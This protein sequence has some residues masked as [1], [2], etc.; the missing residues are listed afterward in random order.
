M[1]WIEFEKTLS[2]IIFYWKKGRTVCLKH[3]IPPLWLNIFNN[4]CNFVRSW[5]LWF[6]GGRGVVVVTSTFENFLDPPLKHHL[7]RLIQYIQILGVYPMYGMLP[8]SLAFLSSPFFTCSLTLYHCIQIFFIT[9]T[10]CTAYRYRPPWRE[11]SYMVFGLV[12]D[13]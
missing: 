9:N 5:G 1:K 2:K 10:P 8:F 11:L 4:N 7:C 6:V 3:Y 13:G 12:L